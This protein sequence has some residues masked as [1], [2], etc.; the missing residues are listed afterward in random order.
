MA[1][2]VSVIY[3]AKCGFKGFEFLLA[4]DEAMP[5]LRAVDNKNTTYFVEV[6]NLREPNS[7]TTAAFSRWCRKQIEEPERFRFTASIDFRSQIEP[8][9]GQEQVKAVKELVDSLADRQRPSE[10]QATLPGGLEVSIKVEDGQP[11]MLSYGTGGALDGVAEK[12]ARTF[13][14]KVLDQASKGLRQLYAPHLGLGGRRLLLLRWRVP[15]DT[16]LVAD[17]MREAVRGSLNGFLAPYFPNLEVHILNNT[18]R[19]EA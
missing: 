9:L 1:E 8:D 13:L 19:L 14:V 6:K 18:D 11:V 12:R 10:F 7:P 4:I 16:W 3:L 2:L 15:S 5:D 17:E